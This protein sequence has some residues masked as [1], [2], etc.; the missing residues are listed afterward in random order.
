MVSAGMDCLIGIENVVYE[1]LFYNIF[2]NDSNVNEHPLLFLFRSIVYLS[3]VL[4]LFLLDIHPLNER[5]LQD[6]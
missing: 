3:I 4:F 1:T 5:I 2:I 6:D